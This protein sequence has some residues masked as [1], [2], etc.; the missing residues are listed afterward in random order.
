LLF[1]ATCSTFILVGFISFRLAEIAAAVV[2]GVTLRQALRTYVFR[3]VFT[4]DRIEYTTMLGVWHGLEYSN[5][6]VSEDRGQSITIIGEDI[7][8]KGTTIH[9]LKSDGNFEQV[10][11]FLHKKTSN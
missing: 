8:G 5:L 3:A 9:L 10:L 4:D 7:M 6:I 11:A 1:V 2:A